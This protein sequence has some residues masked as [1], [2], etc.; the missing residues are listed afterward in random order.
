MN[1]SVLSHD[2]FPRRNVAT[3]YLVITTDKLSKFRASRSKSRI[4]WKVPIK[5]RLLDDRFV[6]SKADY[7][8]ASQIGLTTY[9]VSC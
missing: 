2:L 3:E 8:I 5:R 9:R 6:F 7:H 1:K 4:E